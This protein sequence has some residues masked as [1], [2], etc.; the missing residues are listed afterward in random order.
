MRCSRSHWKAIWLEIWLGRTSIWSECLSHYLG[1]NQ[2]Q[3]R[4]VGSLIVHLGWGAKFDFLQE[5][6][7]CCNVESVVWD[8]G[9]HCCSCFLAVETFPE[10]VLDHG[11]AIWGGGENSEFQWACQMTL[12]TIAAR[13]NTLAQVTPPKDCQC[14]QSSPCSRNV[15]WA[16]SRIKPCVLWSRGVPDALYWS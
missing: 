13:R 5:W 2:E 1:Y 15:C 10:V 9:R 7:Q 12:G 3:P 14:R 16:W 8:S 6:S 11:S 4:A